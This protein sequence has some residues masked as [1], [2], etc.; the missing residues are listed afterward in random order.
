MLAC[1]LHIGLGWGAGMGRETKVLLLNAAFAD[2]FKEGT[3]EDQKF[4]L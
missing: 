2:D 1:V 3:G 4:L